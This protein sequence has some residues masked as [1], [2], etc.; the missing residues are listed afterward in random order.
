LS[1]ELIKN[2]SVPR[3]VLIIGG[4]PAGMEAARVAAL[5]RH[6]VTLVEAQPHLGGMIRVATQAPYLGTLGDIAVWLEQEIY[7]LDVKVQ[8][9]SYMDATD[10]QNENPDVVIVA[11]GATPRMDGIVFD[12][13]GE[14]VVGVAQAH[15]LSSVD[16]LMDPKRKLGKTA[17]VLDAVGHFEALGVCEFLLAKGI[18]VT[19]VTPL[20][21]VSPYVQSTCRDVPTLERF[22]RLGGFTPLVRHRLLEIG[23][24][25]CRI[26]P[27]QADSRHDREI[28]ADTVVLVTQNTPSREIYEEIRSRR[29]AVFVIGDAQSPRDMQAAIA[30]GHRVARSLAN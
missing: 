28:E 29:D 17:V 1:E 27:A 20:A 2:V 24:R 13:P 22:Y 19:L 5:Q 15:V 16:L 6:E 3:K 4:G 12:N 18:E 7:R 14:P 11:T 30:E 10:V 23:A 21:S 25:S 8:L 9:N 26:R